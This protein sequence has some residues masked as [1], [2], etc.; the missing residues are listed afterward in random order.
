MAAQYCV[1]EKYRQGLLGSSPSPILA[2]WE[3]GGRQTHK[4]DITFM[5]QFDP[6]PL[7]ARKCLFKKRVP[8][9]K[10]NDF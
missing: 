1:V 10:K 5:M 8:I 7:V 9:N 3:P 4:R 6:V 2:S